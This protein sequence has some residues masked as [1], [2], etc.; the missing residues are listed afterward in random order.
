[1]LSS[2][3]KIKEH[4]FNTFGEVWVNVP[5]ALFFAAMISTS[6]V[7]PIDNLKTRYQNMYQ[8]PKLNR[9]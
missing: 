8:N 5:I 9:Y 1:M 2:Y 6:I 3:E 4:C 7:L